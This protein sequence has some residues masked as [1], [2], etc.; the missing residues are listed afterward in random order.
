MSVEKRQ[1]HRL[2]AQSTIFIETLS[3]A[4][5]P[6]H[7]TEIVICSSVEV[8]PTGVRVCVDQ[9]ARARPIVPNWY[10]LPLYT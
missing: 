8:S 10:S 3:S 6:Q 4:D 1:W 7:P 5:Q 2:E 9:V